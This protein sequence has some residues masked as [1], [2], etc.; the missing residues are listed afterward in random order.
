MSQR[1]FKGGES[2]AAR[3]VVEVFIGEGGMQQVYR[4]SDRAFDRRVAIK[5]PKNPSAERRFARSAQMSARVNHPHVAKTLDYFEEDGRSFLV[6][7]LIIGT[8]LGELL[9]QHFVYLDPH[10]TAHVLHHLAT[11]LAAAHHA[12]V[13]HRDL[14]PSNVMVSSDPGLSTVKITDFGIAKM[15]EEEISEAVEGG[16]DTITSSQTALG[17]LPYM[18][19]EMIDSPRDAGQP[20]DVWAVG[21]MLY[22]LLAGVA[23]FGRGLKV[24]PAILEAKLP[25]KPDPFDLYPQFSSLTDDLWRVVESCLVKDPGERPTADAL[26]D[27]CSTLCYADSIRQEGEIVNYGQFKGAFGF[28]RSTDGDEVFFHRESLY[29]A[30]PTAGL[31]VNFAKYPGSPKP[32]AYPVLALRQ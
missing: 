26:V 11:G 32:R 5:I 1:L 4:A 18:A 28:I 13:F 6:E 31:R 29:G 21:A 7:E 22:H 9:E 2:L 14:K 19:P 10:L 12:K 8:D 15:A 16:T 27:L 30:K 3:Y 20:A 25:Q 24:V 23:P 17:A